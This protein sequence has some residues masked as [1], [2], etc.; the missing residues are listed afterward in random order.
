MKDCTCHK[1]IY[2]LK[3]EI[4]N[5]NNDI[6][7]LNEEIKT[8]KYN[9][10]ETIEDGKHHIDQLRLKHREEIELLQA[11]NDNL[12]NCIVQTVIDKQKMEGIYEL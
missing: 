6:E 2:K 4:S 11:K 5:L 1:E 9:L 8:L 7:S 10:K 3:N 12:K